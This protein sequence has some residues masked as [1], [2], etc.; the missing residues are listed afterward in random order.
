ML[1]FVLCTSSCSPSGVHTHTPFYSDFKVVALN[2][3]RFAQVFAMQPWFRY[4]DWLDQTCFEERHNLQ[5]EILQ[6]ARTIPKLSIE[7]PGLALGGI[8][9]KMKECKEM[10]DAC[11]C[12]QH[13]L[14]GRLGTQSSHQFHIGW[15]GWGQP[16]YSGCTLGNL[17]SSRHYSNLAHWKAR[18]GIWWGWK[19]GGKIKECKRIAAASRFISIEWGGLTPWWVS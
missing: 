13:V 16:F 18:V 14:L 8:G 7:R 5:K 17:T 9:N 3:S 19:H 12:W 1:Y 10:V 15:M 11:G 2:L 6:A 4:P